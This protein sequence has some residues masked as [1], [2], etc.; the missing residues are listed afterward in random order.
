V[1]RQLVSEANFLKYGSREQSGLEDMQNSYGCNVSDDTKQL[2]DRRHE[3]IE[4][5]VG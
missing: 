3:R 1:E 5:R 4:L 2:P